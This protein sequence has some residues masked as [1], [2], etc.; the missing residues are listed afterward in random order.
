MSAGTIVSRGNGLGIPAFADSSRLRLL[1]GTL[2]YLAQGFP[3]GIFFYAIPLWLA[4][5]D[6][7]TEVV[8]MAA[9][10]A[11]LPWTFKFLAGLVMDR[12]TWLAMGRR[13]PWL[14]GSQTCI[15][16]SLIAMALITP[17]PEQTTLVI[18]FIFVL[19]VLTAV[20]DV[21]LDALVVDLTPESEMGRM[22][23]FMFGGKAFGI[24]AGMAGTGYLLEYHGFASAMLG[25]LVLFAIPAMTALVIRERAGE[26][27]LPWTSG[28]RSPDLTFVNDKWLP[29]LRAA[30][31]NLIRPQGIVTVLVIVTYGVHQRLN[32]M[33]DGLFAIRQLGWNQAEVG[34]LGA[35]VNIVLGIFCLTLGG[36]IVDRFGAKRVAFWSGMTAVP[37][38]GGYLVDTA[39]WDDDRVFVTWLLAKNVPL[40]LFY[41]ANLVIAM[42]V[43]AREAAALSFAIFAAVLPLGFMIGAALLPLLEEL[44]GWRAMY[45]ASAAFVFVAG[46]WTVLLK[47]H[48][49]T[50]EIDAPDPLI[51]GKPA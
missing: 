35:I 40:F 13:R 17:L 21:A 46:L 6:A 24:G 2:L 5:N 16:A 18:G 38:M 30:L 1:L 33:T 29:I 41:L 34:S 19:S 49:N 37:V 3:Q 51:E 31:R 7:S 44:D 25:M 50:P 36:W 12:Y 47:T 32:E 48:G 23:G 4:A 11:S 20:Q 15:I 28:K 26:K 43:T 10:A 8:A 45:G 22:N 39:L 27:L 14:I 9:G 42:Q